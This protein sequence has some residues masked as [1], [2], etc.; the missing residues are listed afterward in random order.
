MRKKDPRVD[1]YI[2]KSADFAK[3]VLN[4]LRQVIHGACPDVEE[5]IKWGFPHFMYEGMLCNMAAFK[6]HCAFM[7]WHRQMRGAFTGMKK[8]EQAMGQLGRITCVADLPST[9]E[10]K[11]QVKAAMELN[12]KGIKSPR[13]V[14]PNSTKKL[15]VPAD[16]EAALGKNKKAR[17]SFDNFSPSR[18]NDY[19]EWVTEAKR[20]ETRAKRIATAVQWIA[21]GKSRNWK[22]ER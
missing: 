2:A 15:R 18:R 8:G 9:S 6:Q 7:F 17:S 1:A 5:T 10:L 21:Q 14:K 22:Y 16:F 3:P 20:P 13:P 19:I 11:R 4:H 12:E